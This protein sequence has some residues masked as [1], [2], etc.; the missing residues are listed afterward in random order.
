MK[1]TIKRGEY[2]NE[3]TET[4]VYLEPLEIEFEHNLK[5]I[6][7]FE[8]ETRIPF[9]KPG[10]T[11]EDYIKYLS[12]ATG[13]SSDE[14]KEDMNVVQELAKYLSDTPTATNLAQQSSGSSGTYL[15]AEVIYAMMF[16]LNI[17]ISCEDWNINR[18]L[19]LIGVMAER[20]KPKEERKMS[21]RDIFEQNKAL[22]EE[23]KR[24]FKT[25]G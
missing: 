22:N 25:K 7:I 15:T 6:A 8:S 16:E 20:Q 5:N 23:R 17:D 4:F 3:Q 1:V 13:V 10:I 9:F 21:R 14:L 11:I 12:I 19:Q 18:L 24:K 2:Y